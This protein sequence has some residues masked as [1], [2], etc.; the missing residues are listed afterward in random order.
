M[1]TSRNAVVIVGGQWGDEGKGKVVDLISPAFDIVARYQG[2][3]NA[4][5]TV[6]FEDRHFAL[7]LVPS[8]IC[9]KGV[10]NVIGNGLVVDPRALVA[11]IASLR[12]AGVT[13]DENLK[14]SDRAHVVL[15]YHKCVDR[16]LETRSRQI[17]VNPY[18]DVSFPLGMARRLDAVKA[19][20]TIIEGCNDFC[21]FCVVPYTRGA[22]VSRPAGQGSALPP[23][24]DFTTFF[25]LTFPALR[26]HG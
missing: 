15:P 21:A 16:A 4:G 14:L 20:V 24:A 9:R 5:H 2:G 6:K 12:A 18:H 10:L 17:D 1:K 19:Y 13:V 8:G 22:E 25:V 26:M 3:H 7:R 11:E 23:A